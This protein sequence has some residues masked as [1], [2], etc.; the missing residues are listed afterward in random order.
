MLSAACDYLISTVSKIACASES[1]AHLTKID[2]KYYYRSEID[3]LYTLS[4][5]R[6]LHK[7][8]WLLI[9]VQQCKKIIKIYTVTVIVCCC[10]LNRYRQCP[11][12]RQWFVFGLYIPTCSIVCY[13]YQ[14]LIYIYIFLLK[15]CVWFFDKCVNSS[16]NLQPENTLCFGDRATQLA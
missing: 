3:T 1:D 14:I 12:L 11:K 8:V 13:A 9:K 10:C 6:N 2:W 4:Q 16:L 15:G 7:H 5:S